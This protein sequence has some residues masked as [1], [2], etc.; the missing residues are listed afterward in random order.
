MGRVRYSR[1]DGTQDPFR[2]G[3]DDAMDALADALLRSGD[4]E[5][6]WQQLLRRGFTS[7]D[8]YR[9]V[10]GLDD[11][12]RE[13]ERKK[14]E[15]LNKY[16]PDSFKLDQEQLQR[17][18]EQAQAYMERLQEFMQQLMQRFPQHSEQMGERLEEL[19]QKYQQLRERL[20]DRLQKRGK[21]E[22]SRTQRSQSEMYEQLS[23]MLEQMNRLLSDPRFLENFLRNLDASAADLNNLMQNL[24][25]LT[26]DQLDQ[27]MNFFDQIEQLEQLLNKFAFRGPEM[28]G[29]QQGQQILR[30]MQQIEDLLKFARWGY[31][32]LEDMDLDAIR[33]VLGQEAAEEMAELQRLRQMLEEAGL[34]RQTENGMQLTPAGQRKIGAK[35]LRDIFKEMKK[36]L[37]GNHQAIVRGASGD[38]T[39]D[40]KLYEF[41]DPFYLDIGQTLKN[42]IIR[43][44]K[45]VPVDIDPADFE[46]YRTELLTRSSTVIMVDLSHSMELYDYNRFTAAKKVALALENLIRTQFPRDK[47]YVVGFGD[48][49]RQ[50]KLDDLP[51]LSVGPEHTNTQEGLELSRKLLSRDSGSNKQII[52]ITDGR[53]TAA[54]INGRL[55][56]HT[57]GLHPAI[58][59]ETYMAAER[60]RR[61]QITINTFMLADDYYLIHFVKEMTRI[62]RGRAFYTTPGRLGEYILVDYI[63]RKRKRIA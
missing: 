35:A 38:R 1:W 13:V 20:R 5:W 42:A 59:E 29:L 30:Q 46:V 19:Y 7:E 51:Y 4:L 34:L 61:S 55:F 49:A 43:Q 14:K 28:M 37:F 32:D 52:M 22:R 23:R 60:C 63:N 41:G 27:L 25:Q 2:I 6:A 58:L 62:C 50:V 10:R 53:P 18:M 48:Y 57:W 39:D 12:M 31:G 40:T 3:V 24:D 16:S 8:G 45:G 36:S 44:H 17:L 21:N 56:I 9:S 54:R 26:D 33:E 11:I 15:L 47:L